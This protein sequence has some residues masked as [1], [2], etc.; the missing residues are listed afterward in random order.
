SAGV[1]ARYTPVYPIK[2][3]Q[4]RNVVEEILNTASGRAGLEAGSKPELLT[5]LALSNPG[6]TIVCNGYKD[7]DYIRLALAGLRM[8]LRVYLVIEKLSELKLIINECKIHNINPLIG[9]RLKLASIASGKWQNS[10]GDR[11]KFGLNSTQLLS[12]IDQLES[13]GMLSSLELLH[14]HLGS[15]ISNIRDIQTGMGEAAQFLQQLSNMNINIKVVDVGGGLGVD[16][17]GTASRSDCSVNYDVTEYANTIIKSLLNVCTQHK[18]NMP[19][20]FSESGRALV[21]HHAVLITNVTEVEKHDLNLT[22]A[23]K[24]NKDSLNKFIMLNRAL[25]QGHSLREVYDDLHDA[26]Q[27]IQ[28]KFNQGLIDLDERAKAE[29]SYYQLCST[30]HQRIDPANASLQPVLTRLNEILADKVFC[31]FSLFQSMPDIW[32]IDQIFPI[33]PLQRLNEK[34][35]RRAILHDLTCDSDGRID[36]YV[37]QHGIANTLALHDIKANE[38]YLLGFF[39]V[40]AYQETLG[41]IHNLFGDTASANV[42]LNE[43]GSIRLEQL[44][45]GEDVD[46]LLS[47]VEYDPAVI[48]QQIL[49]KARASNLTE[50]EGEELMA[51]L[52]TTLQA[53]SYL[54]H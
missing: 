36:L 35:D 10:G 17:E 28:H 15:Q 13:A 51:E 7:R 54:I 38:K 22:A 20:I 9:V 47:R 46:Q 48:R 6:G 49:D 53:Y 14:I 5:V 43:D 45:H 29:Q 18:I 39:M 32:A 8:G 4:N 16:Y 21:A 1:D 2:V 34:P 27:D 33:V 23:G 44:Y 37:D 25:D 42:I 19:D 30:L 12:A 11:S 40:G 50:D 41:D 31:N 26:L 52:Q 24:N 3:N